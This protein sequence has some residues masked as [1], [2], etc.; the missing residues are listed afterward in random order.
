MG[1]AL[2][3]ALLLA[4]VPCLYSGQTVADSGKQVY[5]PTI[6]YLRIHTPAVERY[7]DGIWRREF[8]G[9]EV[10]TI[11]GLMVRRVMSSL[12]E[13]RTVRLEEG[14][15]RIREDS[16]NNRTVEYRVLIE[17]GKTTEVVK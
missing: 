11:D 12:D 4:S 16:K 8:A 14:S 9:Y 6:G 17:G 3:A 5:A 15:Y 2:I 1:K 7:D 13:P 10:Y